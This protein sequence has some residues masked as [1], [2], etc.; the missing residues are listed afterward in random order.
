[1]P[2][3]AEAEGEGGLSPAS[4]DVVLGCVAV[5]ATATAALLR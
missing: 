1:V 4:S 3:V 2:L 5:P